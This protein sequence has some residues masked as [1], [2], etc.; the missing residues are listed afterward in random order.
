MT[1]CLLLTQTGHGT[2]QNPAVPCPYW[3]LFSVGNVGGTDRVL[4]YSE[5]PRSCRKLTEATKL[6]D[7]DGPVHSGWPRSAARK[8][9][10]MAANNKTAFFPQLN[11]TLRARR[12]AENDPIR[13]LG[14]SMFFRIFYSMTVSARTR[15]V[16]GIVSPICLA[17]FKLIIRMSLSLC[18]TGKSA[19]LAPS[20]IRCT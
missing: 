6:S 17:V 5:W 18:S 9:K 7:W 19:G 16:S 8:S 13:T 10:S 11:R 14:R 12:S 15:M 20:R 1:R 3:G 4:L 2:G